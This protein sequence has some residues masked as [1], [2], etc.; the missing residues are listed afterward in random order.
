MNLKQKIL[1]LL[2][3]HKLEHGRD[4]SDAQFEAHLELDHWRFSKDSEKVL[5]DAGITNEDIAGLIG[6]DPAA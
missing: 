1:N 3:E 6:D 4:Y 5:R 2:V